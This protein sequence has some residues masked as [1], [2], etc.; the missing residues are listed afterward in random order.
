MIKNDSMEKYTADRHPE[1]APFDFFRPA[2]RA[3]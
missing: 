3:A 2:A 1:F